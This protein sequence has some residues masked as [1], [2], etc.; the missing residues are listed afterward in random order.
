MST[1]IGRLKNIYFW[2]SLFSTTILPIIA[3]SGLTGKEIS[4]WETLFSIVFSG[5]KNPYIVGTIFV[6]NVAAW[7]DPST[8]GL[9]DKDFKEKLKKF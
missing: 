3:Y 7:I 4:T 8:K 9:I 6:G 2:I 1:K 5:L